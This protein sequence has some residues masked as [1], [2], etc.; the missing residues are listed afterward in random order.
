MADAG[1]RYGN[2]RRATGEELFSAIRSSRILLV[3]AGGIGCELLKTLVLTGFTKIEV[4]DLDTIDVSNLNR[5]FLFRS[6]HVG[7]SKAQVA[8]AA[9]AA[10]NPVRTSPTTTAT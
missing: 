7:K 3:G 5:Q 6:R 9:V 8:S 1:D 4:V 10:F 2:V